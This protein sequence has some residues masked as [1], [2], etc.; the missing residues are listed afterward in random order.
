[1][2]IDSSKQIPISDSPPSSDDNLSPKDCS[3]YS[4]PHKPVSATR[5][6]KAIWKSIIEGNLVKLKMLQQKLAL[7]G[8]DIKTA[9]LNKYGWTALHAACYFGRLPIVEYLI[10]SNNCDFNLQNPNGWHSLIFAVMGGHH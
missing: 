3:P 5:I 1:M 6:L 8:K 4:S 10:E 9:R 7:T 2:T